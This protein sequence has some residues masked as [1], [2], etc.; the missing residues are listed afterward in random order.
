MWCFD[1]QKLHMNMAILETQS[2][3]G[4]I[5]DSLL[6]TC[7]S[8]S[9]LIFGIQ[10]KQEPLI[11]SLSESELRQMPKERFN[12][13]EFSSI[14]LS[15][16]LK[17]RKEDI[18]LYNR[19]SGILRDSL[20]KDELLTKSEKERRKTNR[21][22]FK[23]ALRVERL[24]FLLP[25]KEKNLKPQPALKIDWSKSKIKTNPD[26]IKVLKSFYTNRRDPQFPTGNQKLLLEKLAPFPIFSV[27]NN[28]RQIILAYPPE[29]YMKNLSDK[30]YDYYYRLY[31][32]ESDT[33]ATSIGFFFFNPEDALM[34]ESTIWK[35]GSL[36][37]A[38][39]GTRLSF[40]RFSTAYKLN[41]TSPPEIRFLFIPDVKEVGDLVT[42]YRY[43]Y[44]KQMKFHPNQKI[45][46]DGFA[47]QPIYTIENVQLKQGLFS[48][49]E[50]SYF[51]ELKDHKYIFFTVDGA[52]SAWN[53][54]R[55]ANP[56]LRLPR[57]PN[58][59]VYNFNS[60]I[61]DCEMDPDLINQNF[62]FMLNREA[63]KA[64]DKSKQDTPK[65][66]DFSIF[67][68][69]RVKPQLFLIKIWAKRLKLVLFHAPRINEF[70]RREALLDGLTNFF[71]PSLYRVK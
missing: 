19:E 27:E 26:I 69:N 46:R 58:L 63:Y 10:P 28:L 59:L 32:W 1:N 35:Y 67:I 61:N 45:T 60:F 40:F 33:R 6:L 16:D 37:A 47:D 50:V 68:D 17:I 31:E 42:R 49:R 3:G 62:I 15:K 65:V 38:E 29:T 53:K 24:H 64:L 2:E 12:Q 21:E 43:Q 41:R 23:R 9:N 51:G 18:I 66:S 13:N 5:R 56:N 44:G 36:S 48:R 30:L 70:P 57:R 11:R 20:E 55:Q 14:K 34:Y 52:E 22:K 71:P 54:F 7:Q 25:K 4:N 39:L 8:S